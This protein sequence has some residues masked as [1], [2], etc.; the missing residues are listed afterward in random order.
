MKKSDDNEAKL[1]LAIKDPG[2]SEESEK[3]RLLVQ[4]IG[5]KDK[6]KRMLFTYSPTVTRSSDAICRNRDETSN[7]PSR[8]QPSIRFDGLEIA[9][10]SLRHASGRAERG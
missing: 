4:A 8:H 10:R 3:T 7:L 2:T 9:S 6:D 1:V 5:S